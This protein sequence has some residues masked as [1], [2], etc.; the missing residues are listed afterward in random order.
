MSYSTP[1]AAPTSPISSEAKEASNS[2]PVGSFFL[3]CLGGYLFAIAYGVTFLLPLLIGIRG[4]NEAIAG[5]VISVAAASTVLVV[6]LSGHIAD[7][8]GTAR[9][10]ALSG[11]FLCAANIGFSFIQ[12]TGTGLLLMGLV[13][14]IGWGIFYTL[15]PILVSAIVPPSRR[16]R[17]FALL[18]G[19]MMA[20]IGTG[21]IIGRIWTG[22]GFTVES[23]FLTAGLAS[24]LGYICCL[25]LNQRLREH[26][27][28]ISQSAKIFYCGA[29]Q[30]LKSSAIYPIIMVG[31]GGAI[32]GGLSSFQTSYALAMGLDYSLYFIGFMLA[33]IT[34]RLLLSGYVI[35][36]DPLKSALVFS[37]MILVSVSMFTMMKSDV[38]IYTTAAVLLGVGYGLTYSIING[39]VANEAP[40][41]LTPQALLLFSLSYFIGVF[42]FPLFAGHIIVAQGIKTLLF[43]FIALAV[44]NMS[45]VI[46][47]LTKRGMSS[48][49]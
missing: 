26:A 47:Q 39:Q 25:I 46:R 21:P 1:T 27:V 34:S 17:C 33:A 20:G 13:L 14:G 10:V 35:N 36:K 5:N 40:E 43:V 23:A 18:S 45:V 7:M 32:F 42:G 2:A 48:K 4:G 49:G 8:I 9:S 3:L 6:I 16:S 15:G 24:L 29:R 30:I 44:L 31:L 37:S 38:L 19:S 22:Y 28:V 12:G 41:G 11:L